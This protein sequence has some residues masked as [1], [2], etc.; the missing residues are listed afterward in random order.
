MPCSGERNANKKNPTSR[1]SEMVTGGRFAKCA[2]KTLR[3]EKVVM[4]PRP[5]PIRTKGR[6][7]H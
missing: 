4:I 6:T 5:A 2:G 1:H 3:I 7:G